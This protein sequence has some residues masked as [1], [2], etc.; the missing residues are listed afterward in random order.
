VI[1]SVCLSSSWPLRNLSLDER[2]ALLTL[3]LPISRSPTSVVQE[4][5]RA[6]SQVILERHAQLSLPGPSRLFWSPRYLLQPGDEIGRRKLD[7]L[8]REAHT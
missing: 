1:S 7:A 3:E 4:L 2:Y 8:I 5:R 6:S